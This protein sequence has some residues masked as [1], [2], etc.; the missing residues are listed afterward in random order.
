MISGGHNTILVSDPCISRVSFLESIFG[1]KGST[2]T[3]QNTVSQNESLCQPNNK[4]SWNFSGFKHGFRIFL[5]KFQ[6]LT[7]H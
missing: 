5:T 7:F 6:I 2:Y 4:I 3:R 1:V